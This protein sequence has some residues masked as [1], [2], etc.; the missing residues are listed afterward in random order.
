ME[1]KKFECLLKIHELNPDDNII[2]LLYTDIEFLE[3]LGDCYN[4]GIGT[5]K[6]KDNAIKCYKNVIELSKDDKQIFECYNKIIEL[7]PNDADI[8]YMLA[9]CYYHGKGCRKNHS[10]SFD[11][12]KKAKN[13][14]IKYSNAWNNLR[15]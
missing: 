7:E 3:K 4:Y 10:E 13:L 9:F 11:Y 14:D 15:S 1:K 6:N 5:E 12:C 2:E 8:L